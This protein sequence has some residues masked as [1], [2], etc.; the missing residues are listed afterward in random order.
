LRDD[1]NTPD[2]ASD[3]AVNENSTTS[4]ASSDGE[5]GTSSTPNV[6]NIRICMTLEYLL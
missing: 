6:G 2:N 4:R 3:P 1:L 5:L